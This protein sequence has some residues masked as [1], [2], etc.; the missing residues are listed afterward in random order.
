MFYDPCFQNEV[1]EFHKLRTG[2]KALTVFAVDEKR[3]ILFPAR[4]LHNLRLTTGKVIFD[5]RKVFDIQS[6]TIGGKK[7]SLF[8]W[9]E[10]LER[11]WL[12]QC[13]MD[14]ILHWMESAKPEDV[15]VCADIV[16][17]ES[18]RPRVRHHPLLVAW[19]KHTIANQLPELGFVQLQRIAEML[20]A[21]VERRAA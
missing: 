13:K 7:V 10:D 18:G 15:I 14:E 8:L 17:D 3:R 19:A 16:A 21:G 4:V 9:S 6:N 12:W 11:R 5:N 20:Y 2:R 1:T